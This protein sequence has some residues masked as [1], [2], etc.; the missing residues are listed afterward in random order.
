MLPTRTVYP[1]L[2]E[3]AQ[4]WLVGLY[5]AKNDVRTTASMPEIYFKELKKA[6]LVEGRPDLVQFTE[7]GHRC[8]A[9]FSSHVDERIKQRSELRRGNKPRRKK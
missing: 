7:E 8:I 5:R 4:D 6:G 9:F 2:T 3:G 1:A